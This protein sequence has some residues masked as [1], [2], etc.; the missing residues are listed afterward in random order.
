MVKTKVEKLEYELPISK[1]KL[2]DIESKKIKAK[3][4]G[5]RL[6]ILFT[7]LA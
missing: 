5:K 6:H 7:F 3:K 1:Q 4:Q 2:K